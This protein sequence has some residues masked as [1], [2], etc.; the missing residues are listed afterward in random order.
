[1]FLH[2]RANHADQKQLPRKI[3]V[4]VTTSQNEITSKNHIFSFKTKPSRAEKTHWKKHFG[5]RS[6]LCVAYRPLFYMRHWL[7][8]NVPKWQITIL[9]TDDRQLQDKEGRTTA[10]NVCLQ[11]LTLSF[12]LSPS[13]F[14][15]LF[16]KQRA[17]SQ[18]NCP[19]VL[20]G[21][22]FIKCTYYT[23]HARSLH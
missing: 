15:T 4:H 17:C 11:A 12:L 22:V 18:A 1:M 14:F 10:S 21:L 13:D 16:S 8:S 2:Q 5:T 7:H 9:L 6:K 3:N 19:L 20:E 23:G